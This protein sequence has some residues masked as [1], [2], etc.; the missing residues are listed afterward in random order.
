MFPF[1][2]NVQ[3]LFLEFLTTKRW[4]LIGWQGKKSAEKIGTNKTNEKIAGISISFR[5]DIYECK[6]YICVY[7]N[8][9]GLFL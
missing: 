5:T 4:S 7:V 9:S 1:H 3:V 6:V 2:K 8:N